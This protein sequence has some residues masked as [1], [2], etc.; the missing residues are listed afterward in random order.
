VLRGHERDRRGA[1][2][3]PVGG[4]LVAYWRNGDSMLSPV[5]DGI[6]PQTGVRS[7]NG[8]IAHPPGRLARSADLACRRRRLVLRPFG[9]EAVFEPAG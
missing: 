5:T 1:R 3:G 8:Y 2:V 4:I 7:S 6:G 9:P